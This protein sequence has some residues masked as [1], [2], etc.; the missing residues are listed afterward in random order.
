[1]II[2]GNVLEIDES[3]I[4]LETRIE[5]HQPETVEYPIDESTKSEISFEDIDVGD[6]LPA[7]SL[8]TEELSD[9]ELEQIQAIENILTT[10]VQQKVKNVQLNTQIDSIAD[11]EVFLKPDELEILSEELNKFE[12]QLSGSFEEI[13]I[14]NVVQDAKPDDN[15]SDISIQ[16]EKTIS[17]TEINMPSKEADVKESEA[18]KVIP[19]KDIIEKYDDD[20]D[21]E[22]TI[23]SIGGEVLKAVPTKKS[24]KLIFDE[25]LDIDSII[26]SLDSNINNLLKEKTPEK[27]PLILTEEHIETKYED[28][29]ININPQ[30]SN[31]KDDLK[32]FIDIERFALESQFVKLLENYYTDE[33]DI[34]SETL[35]NDPNKI[36]ELDVIQKKLVLLINSKIKLEINT[37]LNLVFYFLMQTNYKE[38][39]N[40]ILGEINSASKKDIYYNFLGCIYYKLGNVTD[41]ISAFQSSISSQTNLVSPYLSMSNIF[42]KDNNYSE[43]LKYLSNIESRL[44]S[45][46]HFLLL[47]GNCSF[48]L[49]QLEKCT[50]YYEKYLVK[51]P[52]DK[53]ILN[54]ISNIFYDKRTYDRALYYYRVCIDNN[55]QIPNIEYRLAICYYFE[56]IHQKSAIILMHLFNYSNLKDLNITKKLLFELFFRT[57]KLSIHDENAYEILFDLAS[58]L[59]PKYFGYI[60]DYIDIDKITN[61]NILL[62]IAQHYI[63]KEQLDKASLFLEKSIS[64]DEF[65]YNA[66]KELSKLYFKNKQYKEALKMFFELDNKGKT[67]GEIDFLIA[68]FFYNDNQF[69]RAIPYYENSLSKSYSN[70]NIYRCL[71]YCYEKIE[72]WT[73]AI[74]NY[75]RYLKYDM[76]NYSIMNLIGNVYQKSGDYDRAIAEFKKILRHDKNNKEAHLNLSQTYKLII[77]NESDKHLEEYMRLLKSEK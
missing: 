56:G 10:T 77:S 12:R 19:Q 68:N 40:I 41:A 25:D 71:G 57:V 47:I 59:D 23:I 37:Y 2:N 17:Q 29:V 74:E 52:D 63:S 51:V 36:R 20:E 5:I 65:N 24:D 30:F 43:A 50:F 4:I 44:L 14:E 53:V 39:I 67:D 21:E 16:D 75:R 62:K 22:D 8:N 69:K 9:E 76:Y 64:I 33:I 13:I 70:M 54:R 35:I 18:F 66:Y 15:V 72:N 46:E 3:K 38:A 42:Y 6:T 55:V 28:K 26:S 32:E 73:Q 58:S 11:E 31:I 34:F 48:E 27:K 60:S 45:N 7:V 49:K 1:M 61:T